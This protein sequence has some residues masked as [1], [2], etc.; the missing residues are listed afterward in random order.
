MK[1]NSNLLTNSLGKN[2]SYQPSTALQDLQFGK[3]CEFS[4]S[5]LVEHL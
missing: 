4:L 3:L 1:I 2:L 5:D